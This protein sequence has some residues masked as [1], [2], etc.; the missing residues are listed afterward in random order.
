MDVLMKWYVTQRVEASVKISHIQGYVCL[1]AMATETEDILLSILTPYSFVTD[2][3]VLPRLVHNCISHATLGLP[4]T[5]P[6]CK[7]PNPQPCQIIQP[8][9]PTVRK[10]YP[11][12]HSKERH[13]D[14]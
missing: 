7:S 13:M 4:Y 6:P 8:I 14:I 2:P 11:F 9:P 12:I 10:L 1:T 3:A 5:N